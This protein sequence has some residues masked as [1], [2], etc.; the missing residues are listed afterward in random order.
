[1]VLCSW[2]RH[3]THSCTLSTQEWMGTW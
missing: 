1:V 3:F 2:A